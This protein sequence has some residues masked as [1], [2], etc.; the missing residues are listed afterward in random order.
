MPPDVR[1]SAYL[2]DM[3]EAARNVGRFVGVKTR[4]EYLADDLTKSAVERQIEI[5]GE[6]ARFVSP[7]YQQAHPEIPWSG[8]IGQ[9]HRLA[10]DYRIIDHERLWKVISEYIPD[11]L[12]KLE[13]LIPPPPSE[14]DPPI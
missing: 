4:E 1:D 3:R 13:P 8:I 10:H 14:S 12:T 9:R 7:V 11:L 2:W 6:A 5:I